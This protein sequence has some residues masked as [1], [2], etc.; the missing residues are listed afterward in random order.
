MTCRQGPTESVDDFA[1]DLHSLF[2]KAYPRAQ[3]GTLEV[4]GMGQ[5]VLANQF[6]SGLRADIKAKVAGSE[7]GFDQLL[8]KARF[9]E[10]QC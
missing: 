10:C 6:V 7:C 5:S 9:E 4:V 2:Y 8:A 1:Q 3:Q